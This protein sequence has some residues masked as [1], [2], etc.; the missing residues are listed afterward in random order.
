MK[1][2]RMIS[3]VLPRRLLINSAAIFG[4]EAIARLATALMALVVARFYGM[5]ALGNYGYALALASV[6][7][8]VPDFG[9]HLFAV[10]ELSSSP[11]QLPEV[12][13]NVHWLK[14]ALTVAV[15]AFA[16]CF[17]AWGITDRE[18]R[19]VF[20]ILVLRVLLQ[21]FSHAAMAVFKAL[22]RMHYIA[23]QQSVNSAVTAVW[24]A[25]S[26]VMGV[27]LHLLVAGLVVGQLAETLIGW[28][29][30]GRLLSSSHFTR[31]DG[32]A[33]RRMAAASF[34][35]G[36]TAI[37]LALNLRIDI[38]VLSHYVSSRI[39]GQ[40]N[41]A[42]WFVV[43]M[44]LCASLLMS[45]LFP[46]LSRVLAEPGGLGS[47]YIRSLVK[48]VLMFA[49]GGSLLLWSAAPGLIRVFF[50]P[51]FAPAAHILRILSPALPLVFLNTIFFYV[52]AAARRRF[53]CLGTLSA[54]IGVGTLL[55]VYLSSHH[56][57]AGAAT[58]DVAREFIMS[59]AYLCFLIQGNHARFAGVALLKVFG[60]ATALLLVSV[61]LAG[62]FH[63][64]FMWLAAWMF[65]VLMGTLVTL[66]FP[67]I[68][69]WQLLTDDRL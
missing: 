56:G 25:G 1:L 21:S 10:R 31:W 23:L 20:Y 8:I 48:N 52:F 53:V 46:R 13:W 28:N 36:V 30:L 19:V 51:D 60:V 38:L 69:E 33:L 47:D 9:L 2:M 5:D 58:A 67:R 11:Q 50:G 61:R 4:G 14:F 34:P 45:V 39:L 40:F 3:T 63:F 7:L 29:I 18:R 37:L 43:A 55:S 12:F 66:G 24:V 59:G 68:R 17:G 65:F 16:M 54:G 35:F 6:L 64:H 22:E 42:A 44:F 62:M 26:L 41:A 57:A 27:P 15:T 49:A 32:K